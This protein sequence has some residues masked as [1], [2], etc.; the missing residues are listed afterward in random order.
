MLL[1]KAGEKYNVEVKHWV[2]VPIGAGFGSSAAGALT[3]A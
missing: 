2:E 1:A 3:T